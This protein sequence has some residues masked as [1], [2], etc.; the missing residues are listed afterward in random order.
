MQKYRRRNTPAFTFLAYF[1]LFAGVALFGIGMYN[2]NMQ[3]N[4]KGYYIAVMI[5]VAVGAILTQKVTRDNSEDNDILAEQN[6]TNP[7]SV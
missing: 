2:A 1:T 3:L 6:R 5:L 7:P 4:E